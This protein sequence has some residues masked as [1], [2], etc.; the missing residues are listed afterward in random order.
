MTVVTPMMNAALAHN[1]AM[2]P[3]M[4]A[5]QG[6]SGFASSAREDARPTARLLRGRGWREGGPG[7]L[8]DYRR[9]AQVRQNQG[10]E[11]HFQ[12]W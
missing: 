2:M 4:F 5:A 9:K 7:R 3:T 6:V 11:K 12:R 8:G 10:Q 1:A